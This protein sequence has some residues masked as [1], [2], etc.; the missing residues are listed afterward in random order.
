MY[1]VI[2]T[3]GKQYR[4]EVGTELEVELLDVEPGQAVTID[5]VLLVADGDESAIGRPVVAAPRSTPRSCARPA[6]R[7]SSP[8]STAR[9]LDA[10]QEGPSPGA[11]RPSD[12]RRPARR[13]E[14]RRRGARPRLTRKTERQR[15]EEAARSRPQ[16]TPRSPRSSRPKAGPRRPREA[17]QPG[18]VDATAKATA[19]AKSCRGPAKAVRRRRGTRTTQQRIGQGERDT[20]GATDAGEA[21]KRP[22]GERST[23][24]EEERVTD[25]PQESGFRSSRTAATAPANGSASRRATVSPSP[26]GRSSFASAGMTFLRGRAPGLG[27]DYTVFATMTGHVGSS[28]RRSP[29]SGSGSSPADKVAAKA[30]AASAPKAPKPAKASAATAEPTADAE[31]APAPRSRTTKKTDEAPAADA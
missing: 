7:S 31:A 16:P 1:A 18:Q 21:D 26:P 25:G 13:E 22:T 10:R 15:L 5:R 17:G 11:D 20:R 2:E 4:V 24:D 6:A 9:R 8:S 29:R 14:R 27:H 12:H 19:K 30:I 23:G 3:G 28:T